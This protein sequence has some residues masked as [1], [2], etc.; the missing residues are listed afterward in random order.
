[1]A[2]GSASTHPRKGCGSEPRAKGF[3]GASLRAELAGAFLPVL[4]QGLGLGKGFG[5]GGQP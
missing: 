4:V 2:L 5:K 3:E 1:M